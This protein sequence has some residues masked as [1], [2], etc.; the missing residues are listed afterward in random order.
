MMHSHAKGHCCA[1]A[2]VLKVVARLFCVVTSHL[3]L[4]QEGR[5]NY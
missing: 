3:R 4:I 2:K 5:E 1:V